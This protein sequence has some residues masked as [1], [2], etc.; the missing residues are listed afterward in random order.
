MTDKIFDTIAV[1]IGTTVAI[2]GTFTANYPAGK[3]G[4]DYRGGDDHTIVSNSAPALFAKEGDFSI[5]YGTSNMTVTILRGRGFTAGDIIN[6]NLDRAA[7]GPGEEVVMADPEKMAG[8]TLVRINLGKPVASDSDGVVASQAATAAGGL[9]TGIN[10]A[11]ASGGVATFDLPRNVVAAWT[12][13]AV[14]TVTGTDEYGNVIRESSGSGTSMTGKKAFKT[15]TAVSVSADVTGLT[16]GTSKVLGLPVFLAG[17]GEVLRELQDGAA[18][19][20]GT[21]VA[22]DTTAATATTGDVRGTYAPNSNPNGSLLF[23]LIVALRSPEYRGVAQ[24]AG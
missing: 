5:A 17:T 24:F 12:N 22:G 19:T 4:A 2:G 13:T 6:L 18:P 11:L 21:V 3:S 14:L 23:E 10:G 15:V 1:T 20:A 9:A 7:I 8:C 16:V